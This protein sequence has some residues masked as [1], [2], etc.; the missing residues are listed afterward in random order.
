MKRVRIY[1]EPG[2]APHTRFDDAIHCLLAAILAFG[3]LAFGVVQAWSEEVIICLSG[4]IGLV[5]A[6][7]LIVRTDARF[8][9]G[10]SAIPVALFVLLALLQL[11]MLPTSVM[12]FVSPATLS[13]KRELLADLPHAGQLL[14]R[15]SLTFYADA[16]MRQLRMLLAVVIVFGAV[17]NACQRLEDIKRLLVVIASIGAAMAV[18]ALL[19]DATH[20]REIYWTIPT[21][22][23]IA[24]SGTFENHSHFC[25]LMNLSMGAMLALLLLQ[26][27]TYFRSGELSTLELRQKLVS[28][29]FIILWTW[30]AAFV[31]GAASIFFSLS[32]GGVIS[33]LAGAV[34]TG[35]LIARKAHL[36][37]SSWLAMLLGVAIF[38]FLFYFG[39]DAVF[40]RIGSLAH[41]DAGGSRLEILKDLTAAWR[42]FP[43][44]GTGLATYRYVFP[45]FDT[46][47]IPAV[48]THAENE[49]AQMMTE[50]GVI[51][52]V[53]TLAFIVI[54][55]NSYV[56]AVQG[57]RSSAGAVAT[58]LGFG[59]IAIL[60]H[61]L[62][63]FGQHIPANAMLT[64]S[65]CGLIVGAGRLRQHELGLEHAPP[66]F[67]GRRVLRISAGA[68]AAA[69][70]GFLI[71]GADRTRRG[72]SAFLQARSIESELA[73]SQWRGDDSQFLELITSATRASQLQP[74]NVAYRY[75]LNLYRWN[76]ITSRSRDAGTGQ[77]A[78]D[79]RRVD[80][81]RRIV[82]ELNACRIL[83]PS[84]GPVYCILGQIEAFVLDRPVGADHIRKGYR[85]SP[86]DPTATFVAAR[87][88]AS[89]RDWPKAK[90]LFRRT[91]QLAPALYPDVMQSLAID[92][93][94]PDAALE[95][96]E[97]NAP[98]LRSLMELLSART[99]DSDVLAQ[100]R[101]A[102]T[103]L[104]RAQAERPDCDPATLARAARDYA[105]DGDDRRAVELFR[106]ALLLADHQTDWHFELAQILVKAGKTD[107]A[108]RE[109][110]VCLIQRPRFAEAQAL[111][112]KL[113]DRATTRP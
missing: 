44:L 62:T 82:D 68:L 36:K 105:T 95:V 16:T 24:S 14:Q 86:S 31:L 3:P 65:I 40:R 96:A 6:A 110:Q 26:W 54:I 19:Q 94:R 73:K 27:Q 70:I 92:L 56:V 74:G 42:K 97:G 10:W 112:K 113:T 51:G 66:V 80:Y 107:Q 81:A 108:I 48:A 111:L 83:C 20:S 34:F 43:L 67:R 109:L 89:E 79:S 5:L 88:A 84:Y 71:I 41:P 52:V 47:V 18:L 25:Q 78:L 90:K 106:R 61:S 85:L 11:L 75:W 101:R 69:G 63:D 4:A 13:T 22:S 53:L 29:E 93:N 102:E 2:D 59:F 17:V 30:A 38:C 21:W 37:G 103:M 50:M 28:P 46:S 39:S 9:R 15:M 23:G 91:L 32:R 60:V 58:G 49:Y 99:G 33:M 98:A 72:E 57:R 8:V 104:I 64:A 35:P 100:A 77:L 12:G 76:Y 55:W 87:L 7:K 1:F 45:M